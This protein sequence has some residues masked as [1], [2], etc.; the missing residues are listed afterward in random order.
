MGLEAVKLMFN[1]T[2]QMWS[3]YA[4]YID[5]NAGFYFAA[6]GE[7][8]MSVEYVFFVCL[9]FHALCKF[10]IDSTP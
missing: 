1:S 5:S 6:D 3:N 8:G 9:L 7:H 2:G 4:I 10:F